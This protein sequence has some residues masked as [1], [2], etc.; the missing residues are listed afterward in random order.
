MRGTLDFQEAARFVRV[1]PTPEQ[2]LVMLEHRFAS[3]SEVARLTGLPV[4]AVQTIRNNLSIDARS[5]RR[6]ARAEQAHDAFVLVLGGQSA[7]AIAN[8][9]GVS[10]GV[11]S[12]LVGDF[13]SAVVRVG[14]LRNPSWAALRNEAP[15]WLAAAPEALKQMLAKRIAIADALEARQQQRSG[16]KSHR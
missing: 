13:Y 8:V 16:S 10:R 5:S 7:T 2:E 6:L 12:E 3:H 14:V 4:G 15:A 9:L 11:V 1:V